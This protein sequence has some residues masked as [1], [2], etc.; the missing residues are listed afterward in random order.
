MPDPIEVTVLVTIGGSEVGLE[1]A[2]LQLD[3][4]GFYYMLDEQSTE[5]VVV[6]LKGKTT[7]HHNVITGVRSVPTPDSG[8]GQWTSWSNQGDVFVSP[9]WGLGDEFRIEVDNSASADPEPRGGGHFRVIE[10]GSGG[11]IGGGGAGRG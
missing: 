10:D 7:A 4:D 11:T 5:T 2:D 9:A 3:D 1:S 8:N 6:R